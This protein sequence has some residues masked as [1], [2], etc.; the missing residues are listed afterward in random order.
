MLDIAS[1]KDSANYEIRF[2]KT[3]EHQL[4]VNFVARCW[5]SDHVFIR[6]KEILD[7]Q[8]LIDGIYTFVGAF[9]TTDNE[10]HALLG[11]ISPNVYAHREV[12][13][14]DDIWL[15]IWKVDKLSSKNSALGLD[16]L[17]YLD[18][19]VQ[20]STITAIGINK[21]VEGLYRLLGYRTGLL[22]QVYLL[23]PSYE[24][25]MIANISDQKSLARQYCPV[26][27][28]SLVELEW[29]SNEIEE[30]LISNQS[31][32]KDFL[33]ARRRFA[34]HPR[35]DYKLLALKEC[36]NN[37]S[38]TVAYFVARIVSVEDKLCLRILD[39]YSLS[40]LNKFHVSAFLSYL[41]TNGLEYVDLVADEISASIFESIGFTRNSEINFVPHLFEPFD[42]N[43]NTVRYAT[44]SNS[45]FSMIK[46]DSDLDRPNI[47]KSES[48]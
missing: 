28:A 19:H 33:Y 26:S 3:S 32:K 7:F 46:G 20:P 5:R 22:T 27:G 21:T 35:Y 14:G 9:N 48:M 44:T 38:K 2:V 30:Q 45:D 43:I 31:P 6:D 11:F 41:V 40:N 16:I 15:A 1:K 36:S 37:V 8:H 24:S 29:D 18:I 13:I 23:N 25:F 4:L 12:K 34:S 47:S 39:A 17:D 42:P 10:L